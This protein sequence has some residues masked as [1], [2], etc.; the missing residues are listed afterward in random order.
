LSLAEHVGKTTGGW[1]YRRM[2]LWWIESVPHG[3]AGQLV[4]ALN[5]HARK[6]R[7]SG[8]PGRW[9]SAAE[10]TNRAAW[11]LATQRVAGRPGEPLEG[12]FALCG[13]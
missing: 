7:E 8:S 12:P 3:L 10:L 9:P 6:L 1:P 2:G 13:F 4:A 5:V 11:R